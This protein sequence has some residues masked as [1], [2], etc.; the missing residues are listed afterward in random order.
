MPDHSATILIATRNRAG[1]LRETLASLGRVVVPSGCP[2]EAIVIDSGCTDGTPDAVAAAAAAST[3]IPLRLLRE[4]HPGKSRALNAGV[5]AARGEA[6][7]FSDDDVRFP[8]DWVGSMCG[9]VWRGELDGVAGKVRL[10]PHLERA[11]MTR[12]HYDR[13]ADT[14]FMPR[15]TGVMIG[16]NMAVAR[17]V[18]DRGLRF[19]VDLGPGAAGLEEDTLLSM[20]MWAAGFRVAAAPDCVVEH[21]PDP[22]R[23]TRRAWLA[24]AEAAGRSLAYLQHHWERR[25]ARLTG[26]RGTAC[27]VLLRCYRL[28][29]RPAGTDA[30]GCDRREIRLAQ[31]RAYYAAARA[32]R[33][34]PP[35]YDRGPQGRQ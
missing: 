32:L 14:R 9:P 17:R 10:A 28:A 29:R 8:P 25:A 6:L 12:T 4:A 22:S 11:W 24:H 27:S 21:H 35:K 5:A 1:S 15:Q 7:L 33:G 34:L 30:E 20:Q 26:V 19:D 2:V 13:L 23:L 18:F 16:A 3:T 31:L